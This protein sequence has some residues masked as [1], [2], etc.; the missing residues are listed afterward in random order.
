MDN[1]LSPYCQ[2]SCGVGAEW[3][4]VEQSYS[5]VEGNWQQK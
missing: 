3:P 2:G 4:G 5:G 1:W